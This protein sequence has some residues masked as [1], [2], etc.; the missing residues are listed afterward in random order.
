MPTIHTVSNDASIVQEIM[1]ET[2]NR[3][4]KLISGLGNTFAP[5]GSAHAE[6]GLKARPPKFGGGPE[7][8]SVEA[9]VAMMKMYFES[10]QGGSEKSKV[11]ILLTFLHK[12][13]QAWIMQKT[14]TERDSCKKIFDMLLR[15]Y[16]DGP[17]SS[18][19]RLQ[20]D[21]R[22][23][24]QGEKIDTYIY[25]LEG[26]RIRGHPEE[27]VKT[28]NWEIS[29]KFMTGLLDEKL[30]HS[31]LTLYTG[32][33]FALNPPTVE[34]LRAKCRDFLTMMSVNPRNQISQNQGSG[35]QKSSQV[36]NSVQQ[37]APN[38]KDAAQLGN[39][40]NWT[41]ASKNNVINLNRDRGSRACFSCGEKDTI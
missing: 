8:V 19:A 39:N 17:S 1:E 12:Q 4:E 7:D 27:T 2:N 31:L 37:S 41:Q 6:S 16:G 22:K 9:W 14:E 25:D 13:A 36:T 3:F 5:A 32:E 33:Q 20:F 28:R 18:A 11:L 38:V 34:E 29:K 10:Q 26:L 30:P 21:V 40:N 35:Y 23:Q 24:N 15:R